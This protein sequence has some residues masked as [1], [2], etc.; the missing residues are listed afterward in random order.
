[1]SAKSSPIKPAQSENEVH[2]SSPK[3]DEKSRRHS[4]APSRSI[5]KQFGNENH[6][7][8][9]MPFTQQEKSSK[10]R[11]SFAPEVTLH[12]IHFVSQKRKS[13]NLIPSKRKRRETIHIVPTYSASPDNNNTLANIL[14]SSARGA[15][16][17]LVGTTI[18]DDNLDARDD[19]SQ[20]LSTFKIFEDQS[21]DVGNALKSS[22]IQ[23]MTD[24]D[25]N[26]TN[27]NTNME[28][29]VTENLTMDLTAFHKSH[30]LSVLD[31]ANELVSEEEETRTMDFTNFQSINSQNEENKIQESNN[32]D[33]DDEND[34]QEITMDF[35]VPFNK[36]RSLDTDVF[37]GSSKAETLHSIAT[38]FNISDTFDFKIKGNTNIKDNNESN[39]VD[40]GESEMEMEE[41]EIVRANNPIAV[42]DLNIIDNKEDNQNITEQ[43]SEGVVS[44]K[45]E[46]SDISINQ[47]NETLS[48]D[49][50]LTTDELTMDVT[51]FK[52]FNTVEKEPLNEVVST[53]KISSVLEKTPEK[54][55]VSETIS[56]PSS[57]AK[58]RTKTDSNG[59]PNS[60]VNSGGVTEEQKIG[61]LPQ[62][63][64]HEKVE[65][66][67][68]DIDEQIKEAESIKSKHDVRET[69]PI[70][71]NDLNHQSISS[72]I[73]LLTPRRNK[74][75]AFDIDM[76]ETSEVRSVIGNDTT[77]DYT[78]GTLLHLGNESDVTS[79]FLTTTTTTTKISLADV[80][81]LSNDDADSSMDS[82]NSSSSDSSYIAVSLPEF[83][84]DA[85]IKFLDYIDS[86]NLELK[87]RRPSKFSEEATIYDYSKAVQ[88]LPNLEFALHSCNE[89][90]KDITNSR[91]E[92]EELEKDILED[93]PQIIREY[94]DSNEV[95]KSTLR[96]R[97]QFIK[98][99]T[100]SEARNTWYTW[101]IQNSQSLKDKYEDNNNYLKSEMQKLE[102]IS[103]K[104]YN[105]RNELEAQKK[106]LKK[107]LNIIKN[108]AEKYSSI[109]QE[110]V[111]EKKDKL[112]E[113]TLDTIKLFQELQSIKDNTNKINEEVKVKSTEEESLK[114][115]VESINKEVEENKII[116]IEDCKDLK[117]KFE[118]I[119][120]FSGVKFKKFTS[121]SILE[122]S[123]FDD[124]VTL[125]MNLNKLSANEGCSTIIE[126]KENYIHESLLQ[127][128]TND[129]I[130]NLVL[131]KIKSNNNDTNTN[132]L[133]SYIS[134]FTE[135]W[136]KIEKFNKNI[137]LLSLLFP[138]KVSVI[139][140]ISGKDKGFNFNI[141]IIN[142]EYSVN[143]NVKF[144]IDEILEDKEKSN[145]T[146]KINFTMSIRDK[147]NK[148]CLSEH[149]GK[150]DR[151][152]IIKSKVR[153]LLDSKLGSSNMFRNLKI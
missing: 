18:E 27:T 105:E 97:F 148:E 58:R 22:K 31:N 61:E 3:L 49:L 55:N 42:A 17:R 120:N 77:T 45:S 2:K 11:V 20:P 102:S 38:D 129:F 79:E 69:T 21:Q 112:I 127:I 59:S 12:K 37:E 144:T 29:S 109:K 67:L 119:Q 116:S 88:L 64:N 35:T 104:L 83:F 47:K 19:V 54:Q 39:N 117:E 15:F 73:A 146:D 71:E 150:K 78:E 62:L 135:I 132:I 101:N 136:K 6:T 25:D 131:E 81:V 84:K 44:Q 80:S 126:S 51:T 153:N 106:L 108:K 13:S 68:H 30:G 124:K 139:N 32:I 8:A 152:D 143:F 122:L 75:S 89:L 93:N 57:S 94:Y 72:K 9:I 36:N 65:T 130:N 16:N 95:V 138:T 134:E 125:E 74:T 145:E 107:K 40:D 99:Y 140:D 142:I 137:V 70:V 100:R 91:E 52:L 34:N 123:L 43:K 113:R 50:N 133:Y 56:T 86:S 85:N 121:D 76:E 110:K 92:F 82:I 149:T 26:N 60:A 128:F 111:V 114:E 4:L 118:L 46:Q 10:R 5:L 41:T 141:R 90:K 63:T 53:D 7:L 48:N 103:Q 66:M 98:T 28:I 96:D 24:D 33:K 115:A 23:N 87:M 151:M 1:M 14:G 147:I